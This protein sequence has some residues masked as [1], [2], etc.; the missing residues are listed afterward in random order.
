M[1]AKHTAPKHTAPKPS[2][3]QKLCTYRVLWIVIGALLAL[4]VLVECA[5]LAYRAPL[6]PV[7]ALWKTDATQ[8][9]VV[10]EGMSATALAHDLFDKHVINNVPAFLEVLT[11]SGAD[12]Q[13]KIGTYEFSARDSEEAIVDQLTIGPNSAKGKLTV[14]EGMTVKETAATVEKALGIPQESFL[15]EAKASNFSNEF[16]FLSLAANDSL[17]GFLYGATYDFSGTDPNAHT[18]I[19]TMLEKMQ[20]V[21]Q[22]LDFSAASA[23]IQEVY[24]L[25]MNEYDFI[26]LA[27]I[28]QKEGKVTSDYPQIASTFYNR[29][30]K[31]MYLQS[32]ATLAYV[33][34]RAATAEDLSRPDPYNSYLA[35][36]LPPTPICS[37]TEQCLEAALNPPKTDYFY[38]FIYDN[39]SYSNHT[40]SKTYEE[41]LAAIQ[42]ANKEGGA[43][44]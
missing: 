33:L 44:F 26:K 21:L 36:G 1:E 35:A 4:I 15:E 25:Q 40:F 3:A 11:K 6:W 27:S 23:Q 41:H 18:V 34:G 20:K 38:F 2:A 24:G 43:N 16:D 14:P 7:S 32:D 9:I 17:E 42:D 19:E 8:E 30:Q 37:P 12:A 31:G 29:M 13:I 28:V 5:A 10:S 22:T 39:G